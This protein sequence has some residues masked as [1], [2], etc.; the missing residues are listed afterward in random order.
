MGRMLDRILTALGI[1]SRRTGYRDP[2]TLK[3]A[4]DDP[5]TR[6]YLVD[7]RT[8]VEYGEGHIPG[9]RN[10][11]HDRIGDIPPT[12]AKESDIVVYCR[13]GSRSSAAERK[14]R[15][16]G[17]TNVTNFGGL[18]DWPFDVSKGPPSRSDA[19]SR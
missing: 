13:T 10:I 7:V 9:A 14:L 4:L 6:L 12:E 18:R 16:M 3:A 2:A 15:A 5:K 1:G 8:D 11:P 17:Y 19:G